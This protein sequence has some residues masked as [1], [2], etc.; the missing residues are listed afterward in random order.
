ME[1]EF[2]IPTLVP[3]TKWCSVTSYNYTQQKQHLVT[4]VSITDILH[5]NEFQN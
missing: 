3:Q 2:A 1:F 5:W 4:F